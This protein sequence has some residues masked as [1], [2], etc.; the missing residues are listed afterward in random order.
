MNGHSYGSKQCKPDRYVGSGPRASPLAVNF[1]RTLGK[2]RYYR[3]RDVGALEQIAVSDSDCLSSA[4]R[5]PP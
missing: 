5:R 4:A 1:V 2:K 3:S